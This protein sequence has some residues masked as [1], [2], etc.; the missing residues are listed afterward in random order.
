M[1]TATLR[2]LRYHFGRVEDILQ[3]EREIQITRRKRVIA[4]LLPPQP[5]IE[6]A[7]PDF[8]SRLRRIYGEKVLT[9][10]GGRLLAEERD[11]S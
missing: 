1:R 7:R 10:T 5:A 4:R 8:L 2:D 3:Q 6:A 11:R 9:T